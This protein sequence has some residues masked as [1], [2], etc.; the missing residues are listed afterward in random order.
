MA[1]TSVPL[2]RAIGIRFLRWTSFCGIAAEHVRLDLGVRQ[3]D[4]FQAELLGEDRQQHF[5]LDEALVDEHLVGRE[6]GGGLDGVGGPALSASVSRPRRVSVSSNCMGNLWR[7][8]QL[9]GGDRAG[10]V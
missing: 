2:C 5:F 10:F 6:L 7:L 4:Q 8:R 1:T 3:V 9:A